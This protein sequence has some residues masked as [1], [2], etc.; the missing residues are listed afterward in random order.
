MSAEFIGIV[1]FATAFISIL[2]KAIGLPDQIRKNYRRKSTEGLSVAFFL[3]SVLAYALWTFYG[4]LKKDYVLIFGQGF[5]MITMVIIAYQIW[6]YKG[7]K[8]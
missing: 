6:L 1:G 7:K 8:S 4:V 2:V 5:G 3:L